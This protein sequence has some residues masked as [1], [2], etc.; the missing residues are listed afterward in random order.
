MEKT[1]FRFGVIEG[2]KSFDDYRPVESKF[3]QSSL[4]PYGQGKS[5]IFVCIPGISEQEFLSVVQ[6]A[7][8]AFAVELR[9]APRFDIGR[10]S[11]E[12][13]FKWFELANCKYL[14]PVPRRDANVDDVEKWIRATAEIFRTKIARPIMF[15]ISSTQNTRALR[16]AVCDA[17]GC[18]EGNWQ[19]FEVPRSDTSD[20]RI[21]AAK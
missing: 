3:E 12:V 14:D 20:Q 1:S 10:L 2:G 6:V 7:Q 11:R 13:V 5:I 15:F 8:P 17:L 21:A 19:I 16:K 4:F 9:P 18:T